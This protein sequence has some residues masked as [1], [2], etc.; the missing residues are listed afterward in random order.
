MAAVVQLQTEVVHRYI[1]E[2]RYEFGQVYWDRAGRIAKQILSETSDWDFDT[3]DINRCQLAIRDKNLVFNFGHAKLDLVQTQSADVDTLLP[4]DEFGT[5]AESLAAP[6]AKH[7]ELDFYTRIG[8][9]AWH[10]YPSASR[11]ESH[12]LVRNLRL[13]SLDRESLESLG[14]PSEVSH[15]LV[16]DRGRHM[17]RIAISPFEQHVDLPPSVSRAVRVKPHKQ[18]SDQRKQALIDKLKAERRI[19]HFPRFGLLLDVDAYIEDPPYPD[20]LSISDFVRR[21]WE[22]FGKVKGIALEAR[23]N[24]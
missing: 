22:D 18:P 2:L 5:T 21:A 6:V 17:L 1:L 8:F 14:V 12:S 4:V 23:G 9:R 15:R 11:E 7:L 3:I 16:V 10:L 24:T 13:F 19:S 20:G